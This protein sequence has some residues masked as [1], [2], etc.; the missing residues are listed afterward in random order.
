MS[1]KGLGKTQ[2]GFQ[3]L[4]T[5]LRG[6]E[7]AVGTEKTRHPR[8][9]SLDLPHEALT[10]FLFSQWPRALIWAI[11]EGKKK[12]L[13]QKDKHTLPKKVFGA[14]RNGRKGCSQ[15]KQHSFPHCPQ[16]TGMDIYE[17]KGEGRMGSYMFVSPTW[18]QNAPMHLHQ[19]LLLTSPGLEMFRSLLIGKTVNWRDSEWSTAATKPT[20]QRIHEGYTKE[21]KA[22]RHPLQAVACKTM[23]LSALLKLVYKEHIFVY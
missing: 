3:L 11:W 13:I 1:P 16:G 7:A 15:L 2:Q 12:M 9:P 22:P 21:P 8:Q 10:I 20:P 4:W 5:N 18:I 19:L 23:Q 14:G 17:K 6:R